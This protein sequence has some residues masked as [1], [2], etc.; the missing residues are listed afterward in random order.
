MCILI[1]VCNLYVWYVSLLLCVVFSFD[2]LRVGLVFMK[3]R[4]FYRLEG[5][6]IFVKFNF[7]FIFDCLESL[8]GMLN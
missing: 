2:D 4:V 8:D 6:I 7:F 3:R 5:L 1:L